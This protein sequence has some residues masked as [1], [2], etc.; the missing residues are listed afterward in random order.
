MDKKEFLK[1]FIVS[2]TLCSVANIVYWLYYFSY[3]GELSLTM[4]IF[5]KYILAP[6]LTGILA[7]ISTYLV[8]RKSQIKKNTEKMKELSQLISENNKLI[9][10]R[11]E[12]VSND[13]GRKDYSSLTQQHFDMKNVLNKE[14][15][16][17]ERRYVEEEKRLNKFTEEQHNTVQ[18]LEDFKMFM[19]SWEKTTAENY[20]L[21]MK[22]ERLENRIYELTKIVEKQNRQQD[23][24]EYSVPKRERDIDLSL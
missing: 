6:I 15:D 11:F 16:I 21:K 12:S 17:V 9:I 2:F 18:T 8:A 13:I 1:C 7:L 5:L 4:D 22:N 23:V 14:I 19:K 24:H 10:E 20:D 3:K